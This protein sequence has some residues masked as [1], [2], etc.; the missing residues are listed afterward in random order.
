MEYIVGTSGYSFPDWVGPFYPPGTRQNEMF[1][2]YA[3]RF[4]ALELNFTFYRVPTP[5]MIARMGESSPPGFIFWVKANQLTTHKHDRTIAREFLDAVTPLRE[6]GK[7]AGLLMQFPQSFHRTVENR[8]YLSQA[9]E[10]YQSVPLAVEFRHSSWEHPSTAEGLRTRGVTL[11]IPDVPPVRG[12]YRAPATAT[13]PRGYLR[14]HSRDA[15]KWYV[16]AAERYDYEYKDDELRSLA[17]SW[18]NLAE[19]LDEVY[20]FFNNCHSGKAAANAAA[21]RR[22]VGQIG[23]E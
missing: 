5:E 12:L 22:V 19:Q 2:Y 23:A 11:V 17:E 8:M 14:L 9:I 13:T 3:R 18:N 16:G 7:L 6:Q 4:S 10:D 21:F 1:A 15:G 20:V